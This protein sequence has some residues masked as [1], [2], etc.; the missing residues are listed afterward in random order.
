MKCPECGTEYMDILKR[1]PACFHHNPK[2]KSF[3]N[4]FGVNEFNEQLKN[5]RIKIRER[6]HENFLKLFYE[7]DEN[8]DRVNNLNITDYAQ[9]YCYIKD[10]YDFELYEEVEK[11][12]FYGN[13]KKSETLDY[14]DLKDYF[15]YY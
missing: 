3:K 4:R 13:F 8:G 9:E 12:K 7:T 6:M 14:E 5:K 1:C 15:F 10:Y 2:K 11:V